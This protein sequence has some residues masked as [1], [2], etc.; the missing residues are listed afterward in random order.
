MRD[1]NKIIIH[2]SATKE[3]WNYKAKD[4]DAWHRERGFTGI[5]YHFVIDING[6]V[7]IGRPVEQAGA[8]ASGHNAQSIGICYIGGLDA[9]GKAKDTRTFAQKKAMVALVYELMDKYPIVEVIGHRDASPDKDGNGVIT[10][11]EWIKQCPC[12]DVRSEFPISIC[13]AKR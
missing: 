13:R 4:I 12:F 1:I 2:C 6:K 7:E 3:G 8:H 5:G 9:N 10:P 11:N